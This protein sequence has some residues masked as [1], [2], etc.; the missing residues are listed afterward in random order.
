M[1]HLLPSSLLSRIQARTAK[2]P[3][4]DPHT[5]HQGNT[6]TPHR[7]QQTLLQDEQH[8]KDP[9]KDLKQECPVEVAEDKAVEDA[10]PPLSEGNV[11]SISDDG[12]VVYSR[13]PSAQDMFQ[14]KTQMILRT[15]FALDS[16]GSNDGGQ[17]NESGDGPKAEPDAE[18]QVTAD[19]VQPDSLE[20][21][22][23][24]LEHRVKLLEARQKEMQEAGRWPFTE[25][26]QELLKAAH[27]MRQLMNVCVLLERNEKF[28][29]TYAAF[30]APLL[31][32]S[33]RYS[34]TF[35][36]ASFRLERAFGTPSSVS[37]SSECHWT[38][39]MR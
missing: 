39:A 17:G 3:A 15:M 27:Q 11:W 7:L 38:I 16:E 32:L 22:S 29:L 19:R 26:F 28:S 4:P 5:K 33:L 30:F 6:D 9:Q 14:V 18:K 35:P 20:Q 10:E 36:K 31:F 25:P 21:L 24:N 12:N 8:D 13:Y 2:T 37:R 34:G 1:I 23:H